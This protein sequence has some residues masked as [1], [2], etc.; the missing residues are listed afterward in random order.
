MSAKRLRPSSQPRW[1]QLSVRSEQGIYRERTPNTDT[2]SLGAC[3]SRHRHHAYCGTRCWVWG[4]R[5]LGSAW[6]SRPRGCSLH[7][8]PRPQPERQGR[9]S[10]GSGSVS[11]PVLTKHQDAPQ[12]FVSS[13]AGSFIFLRTFLTSFSRSL[14][15]L[16]SS[17]RDFF[18]FLLSCG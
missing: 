14:R 5:G 10:R 8:R 18:I 15:A 9:G 6:S 7:T 11:E 16:C 4:G 12:R 17:S 13:Q 1:N 2:C 3:K